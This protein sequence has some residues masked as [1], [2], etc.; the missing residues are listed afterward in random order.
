MSR[1]MRTKEKQKQA[2]KQTKKS[3]MFEPITFNRLL[4]KDLRIER[5]DM[6]NIR[7]GI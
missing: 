4:L 7:L 1:A 5:K 2:N 6:F 3:Y